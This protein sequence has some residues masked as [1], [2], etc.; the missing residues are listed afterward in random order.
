M[1][2]QQRKLHQQKQA[3]DMPHL[4]EALLQKIIRIK[5]FCQVPLTRLIQ[6]KP[7]QITLKAKKV[8]SK[9]VILRQML[10]PSQEMGQ[11]HFI[12][13]KLRPVK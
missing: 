13:V 5:L 2:V 6:W 7:T 8:I 12:L 1:Q 9:P 11:C 10:I 4:T 3:A